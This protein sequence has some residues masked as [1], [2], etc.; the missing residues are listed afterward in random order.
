MARVFV[1]VLGTN[2][3]VPCSYKHHDTTVV[4][5]TRFVQEA[6]VSLCCRDWT[7][8]DRV[9]I[10]TTE[11]AEKKNW[12][13]DGHSDQ[14]TK[15]PIKQQGLKSILDAL[16]LEVP[17]TNVKIPEGKSEREIWEI[18]QAIFDNLQEADE[19]VFDIT[20]AFRSIPMLVMVV[21]SYAKVIKSVSLKGIYYGAFEVLGNPRDVRKLPLAK[22]VAPIFDLTPFDHLFD[23]TVAIGVFVR[24]GDATLATGLAHGHAREISRTKKGADQG[25]NKLREVANLLGVFSKDVST[26][27]GLKL[28]QDITQLRQAIRDSRESSLAPAFVPLLDQLLQRLEIFSGKEIEDGIRVAEWCL[29][30]NLVQQGYTILRESLISYVCSGYAIDPSD[31]A[32]RD[33]VEKAIGQDLG[34]WHE[35]LM[36]RK[37][38]K[39][40]ADS[41]KK[42]FL[43]IFQ[44]K[45]DLLKIFDKLF[46]LRNDINHAGIRKNPVPAQTLIRE[47]GNLIDDVKQLL[48]R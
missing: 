26:C 12:L 41:V 31:F 16:K 47:L 17:V 8:S 35:Y 32:G 45:L 19:I 9:L 22:R 4:K 37:H 7:K 29:E 23:W 2:D 15:E 40:N 1:S 25:A 18:F 24:S 38:K 44:D 28:S 34:M 48:L 10:F 11:E 5:E 13:D 43:S 20:H 36:L 14:R 3:Y 46:S 33:Q 42:P 30:H 6:T 39:Q 21:L 27:R